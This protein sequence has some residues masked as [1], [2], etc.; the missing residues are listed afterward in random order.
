MEQDMSQLTDKEI[1]SA[2]PRYNKDGK[3]IKY[4]LTDSTRER[5][6][7]S[8]VVRIASLN[9][10]TF[11][12]RFN[13][14]GQKKYIQIGPYPAMS[15]AQARDEVQQFKRDNKA[16]KNP[17][18]EY[19]K[20]NAAQKMKDYEE[21]KQGTVEQLFEAYTADMKARDKSTHKKVLLDLK[22]E[23]FPTIDRETRAKDTTTDEYVDILA[24]II[25]RGASVQSNRIRSYLHAAF[26]YGLKQDRDPAVKHKCIKFGLKVNPISVIPKQ[27]NVEKP[28]KRYLSIPVMVELIELFHKTV[29]VGYKTSTLLKLCIYTGGQRPHEIARLKWEH[30]NFTKNCILMP[31]EITK[32]KREHTVPFNKLTLKV[33][34][35]LKKESFNSPY[36][37]PKSTNNDDHIEFTTISKGVARFRKQFSDFPF[38]IPRDIR[39]SVKTGLTSN[40]VNKVD[41]DRVHNHA[42]NDVSSKHYDMYEYF[43]EKKEVLDKWNDLLEEALADLK[44]PTPK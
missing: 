3:V 28:G 39:R 9:S 35:E 32:N 23:V 5:G 18:V 1:R 16:G 7:G 26:N 6:T 20:K 4:D 34:K 30:I 15:L 22:K 14:S 29:G 19:E 17:K 2:K 21:S 36:L 33:L 12:Y 25:N 8:L 13:L 37:F 44:N 11:A 40:K 31:A 38:F 42:R 10:K 41:A 27:T 43:D 24:G